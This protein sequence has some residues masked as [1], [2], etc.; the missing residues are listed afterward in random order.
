MCVQCVCVFAYCFVRAHVCTYVCALVCASL[1]DP[2]HSYLMA[3]MLGN[4]NW[5]CISCD[6]LHRRSELQ[7]TK[8]KARNLLIA[9]DLLKDWI[10]SIHSLLC[11]NIN[12]R[13]HEE[14][15]APECP[16]S[17]CC[18]RSENEPTGSGLGIRT[19]GIWYAGTLQPMAS[20]TEPAELIGFSAA[21]V[22]SLVREL[23]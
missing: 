23:H 13:P 3:S 17:R 21:V 1:I 5:S 7:I 14:R 22:N 18:M 9:D 16:R 19:Y 12:N 15:I 6:I 4:T 2:A 8:K 20:S 11:L 10:P